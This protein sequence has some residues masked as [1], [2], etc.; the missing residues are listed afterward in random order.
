MQNIE[1][2]KERINFST[3][4]LLADIAILVLVG[5]SAFGRGIAG[6]FDIAFWL[7]LGFGTILILLGVYLFWKAN[8]GI[9]RLE[10]MEEN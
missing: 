10:T 9:E 6:R 4:L 5:G 1:G 2:V 3:R 7:G 8:K